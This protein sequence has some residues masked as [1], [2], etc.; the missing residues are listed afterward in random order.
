[1]QLNEIGESSFSVMR[2]AGDLCY[3]II[4]RIDVVLKDFTHCTC[5]LFLY[6]I[7]QIL[8]GHIRQL[9]RLLGQSSGI[10]NNLLES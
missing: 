3:Q 7:V 4:F 10:Q 8:T 2:G 1:M 6:G 9:N 5:G